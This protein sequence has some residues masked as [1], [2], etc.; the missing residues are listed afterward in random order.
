MRPYEHDQDLPGVLA[1]WNELNWLGDCGNRAAGLE[2]FL[3]DTHG[4]VDEVDGRIE[5][6][7]A[8]RDG[9]VRHEGRTLKFSA[10]CALMVSTVGRLGGFG[11]RGSA[12]AVADAAE[13]GI[14]V[15][16]L[17]FFDQGFYDRIGFGTGDYDHRTTIDPRTL[18]VP[19]GHRRPVR[20]GR[21]DLAR[22]HACRRK[23]WRWHGSARFPTPA[24]TEAE[25][26]WYPDCYYLGF[27]DERGELT[28]CLCARKKGESGP[29]EVK[30]L[31]WQN[32]EQLFEL[33]GVFKGMADSL[34]AI[35]IADPPGVQ[36]QDLV[37]RPFES[38]E[39]REGG[40]FHQPDLAGAWEQWRIL[41]P[42]PAFAGVRAAGSLR[43][44]VDLHDPIEQFLPE[45]RAWRG[46]SGVWTV[47]L[48]E[49][50]SMRRGGSAPK[51]HATVNAFSRWW[52]GARPASHLAL[53][54]HFDGSAALIEDLDR[55]WRPPRP[56]ND[57]EF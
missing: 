20:L 48:G 52:L 15:A 18:T 44:A 23:S 47:E 30:W 9:V 36:L 57:W 45:D 24:D 31:A 33:L 1:L 29:D 12:A 14:A 26:L 53:T 55:C 25:M 34:Y 5:G 21:D 22:I 56:R 16:A 37:E 19:K 35:R 38:A 17:G 41:Q 54:D 27:E 11:T 46:L 13:R 51:L 49:P 32:R 2:A 40:P 4:I 42:A 28:H 10:L 43:F 7:V 39:K 8:M 3:R 6:Q 50:C